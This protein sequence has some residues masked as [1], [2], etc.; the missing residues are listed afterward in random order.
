MSILV[1]NE[2]EVFPEFIDA[3][4]MVAEK[5]RDLYQKQPGCKGIRLLKHFDIATKFYLSIEWDSMESAEKAGI[6]WSESEVLEEA[7]SLLSTT[8]NRQVFFQ[9]DALGNQLRTLLAGSIVTAVSDFAGPGMAPD[10]LKGLMETTKRLATE[11]GFLGGIGLDDANAEEHVAVLNYW[12]DYTSFREQHH[13][14][15]GKKVTVMEVVL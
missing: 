8:P 12:L 4:L 6:A 10:A 2:V 5:L 15:A 1:F 9:H 11:Y 7:L 3:E 13:L 14:W